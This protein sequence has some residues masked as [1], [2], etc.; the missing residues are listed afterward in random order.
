[1]KG[2]VT[3]AIYSC[4]HV[5][6]GM[7][8]EHYGRKRRSDFFLKAECPCGGNICTI[9]SLHFTFPSPWLDICKRNHHGIIGIGENG[10]GM[11]VSSS[12]LLYYHIILQVPRVGFDDV[13]TRPNRLEPELVHR[14]WSAITSLLNY[15]PLLA[16]RFF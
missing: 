12:T 6:T 15:I 13:I 11:L 14:G 10:D 5:D 2:N 4:T 8:P 9:S 7:H 16:C 1:M 3:P